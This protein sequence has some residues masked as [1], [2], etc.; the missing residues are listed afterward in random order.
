MNLE[1][2]QISFHILK[3]LL[4]SLIFFM[5]PYIAGLGRK[6]YVK[7]GR[8]FPQSHVKNIRY[9]LN[10]QNYLANVLGQIKLVKFRV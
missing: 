5:K 2:M 8:I 1:V 6:A 9:F 4:F 7:F 3:K 10:F